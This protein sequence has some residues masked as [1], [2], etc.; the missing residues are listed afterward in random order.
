M[1][2]DKQMFSKSLKK[3]KNMMMLTSGWCRSHAS[4]A[5]LYSILI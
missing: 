3:V 4:V 1:T 5:D 2:G